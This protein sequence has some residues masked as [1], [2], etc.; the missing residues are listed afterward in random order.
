MYH[1]GIRVAPQDRRLSDEEWGEIAR[2]MVDAAGLAPA[3]DP[4][5]V[6][7]VAVRHADDHIHVVA[8][9]ARQDGLKPDVNYDIPRMQARARVLE[10]RYGLRRLVSGDRTAS[11]WLTQAEI[12]KTQRGEREVPARTELGR[13]VRRAAATAGSD[14][15]FFAAVQACGVR[16]KVRTGE[17]GR[18]TGY[19]V[20]LPGDRTAGRTAVW[21]S[22]SRLAPDLSLPRVRER[23]T[24]P[25]P[26]PVA[27]DA[28]WL[29]CR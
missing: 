9:M 10:E 16:L 6:R 1:V 14:E 7:W 2:E 20:A 25:T 24:T 12:E 3:G 27:V 8:T 4:R 18:A 23:W 5:A 21:Y 28:T 26:T 15:E 22:G 29:R 13:L 19:A 17:R 11:Q